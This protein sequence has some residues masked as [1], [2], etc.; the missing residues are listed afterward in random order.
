MDDRASY[1]PEGPAQVGHV[2]DGRRCPRDLEGLS[3]KGIEL[4][5]DRDEAGRGEVR[6]D[7]R[8]HPAM[9]T[10]PDGRQIFVIYATG[11]DKLPGV[12]TTGVCLTP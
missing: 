6:L 7:Q 12:L 8:I 4:G 11:S 5:V 2:G 10:P 3:I 9:M 1:P